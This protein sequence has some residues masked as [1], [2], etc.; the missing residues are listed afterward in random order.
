[1]SPLSWTET[2]KMTKSYTV[3]GLGIWGWFILLTSFYIW[4]PIKILYISVIIVITIIMVMAFGRAIAFQCV[5][6][7]S[8]LE[9]GPIALQCFLMFPAHLTKM[10]LQYYSGLQPFWPQLTSIS[11]EIVDVFDPYRRETQ[12]LVM[13]YTRPSVPAFLAPLPL[14]MKMDSGARNAR[15]NKWC[16]CL[17][18]LQAYHRLY[19]AY[20]H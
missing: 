1:M 10:L 8:L 3:P 2:A 20:Q 18:I 19:I 7:L 17:L 4:G 5:V 13:R 15:W 16:F 11:G 14:S 12:A 9:G 6:P